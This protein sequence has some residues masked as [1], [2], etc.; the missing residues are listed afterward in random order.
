MFRHHSGV[1]SYTVG[2]NR[3]CNAQGLHWLLDFIVAQQK[4]IR[5][6]Q[7][8]REGQRWVHRV[9]FRRA[10]LYCYPLATDDNPLTFPQRLYSDVTEPEITLYLE[11]EALRLEEERDAEV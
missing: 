8:F 4:R 5:K 9:Q 3:V 11:D 6:D 1:F 10:T 2:V 7:R